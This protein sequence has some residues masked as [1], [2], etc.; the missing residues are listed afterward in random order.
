MASQR[1]F[2]TGTTGFL[3]RHIAA[4]VGAHD[5][6]AELRLL[7]RAGRAPCLPAALAARCQLVTGDLDRPDSYAAALA[8]VDTVIHSAAMVSFKAT[9]AARI[10]QT[11]IEGTRALAQA[12]AAG[13]CQNFIHI[14]S[15]SAIGLQPGRPADERCEPEPERLA[16]DPYAYSKV[17]A[18]RAVLAEAARLRVTLLN[19][20]VIIGPGSRQWQRALRWLRLAPALPMLTTLNSFVDARDV[21]RAVVL[22]LNAPRSGERYIVTTAN[23]DMLTFGRLALRVLGSRARV[24]SVS[25][26]LLRAG[27]AVLAGLDRL[28][29]NPGFKRLAQLNVDKAYSSEKITRELG[30]RPAYSL[31]QSVRDTLA[32]AGQMPC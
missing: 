22:A 21:A 26:G 30:W 25:P 15:I 19:P 27:D 13:D 31:E 4:A 23:V 17:M 1:Y 28:R 6:Q 10:C 2:I 32:P 11:N 20:S 12:A 7:V 8:G 3:G 29:L 14:S 16:R 9:A 5:P 24:F 18:E